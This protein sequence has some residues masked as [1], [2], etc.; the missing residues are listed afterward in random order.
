MLI[1]SVGMDR[2]LL[3]NPLF[4][5]SHVLMS[6]DDMLLSFHVRNADRTNVG[7]VALKLA[8]AARMY[9]AVLSLLMPASVSDAAVSSI[10]MAPKHNNI[11]AVSLVF[12]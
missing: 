11:I 6:S 3:M 1:S 4:T 10:V 8:H 2:R 12:L 9:A 7:S 5:E